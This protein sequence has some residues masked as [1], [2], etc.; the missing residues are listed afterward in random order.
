MKILH[1][2]R[3]IA[4]AALL[5]IL[6][7][8]CGELSSCQTDNDCKDS[9]ICE[10]NPDLEGM[11]CMTPEE[12]EDAR[13]TS[14]EE[15]AGSC[16]NSELAHTNL[17]IVA[18]PSGSSCDMGTVEP[19]REDCTGK[20]GMENWTGRGNED[21]TPVYEEGDDHDVLYGIR[22]ITY[23]ENTLHFGATF[24]YFNT[25]TL[26]KNPTAGDFPAFEDCPNYQSFIGQEEEGYYRMQWENQVNRLLC[27]LDS[28]SAL[29]WGQVRG[30]RS[31]AEPADRICNLYAVR[32]TIEP[33]KGENDCADIE[34]D[35]PYR[36]ECD[37][38]FP[39]INP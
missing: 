20:F 13:N 3:T 15:D 26:R 38:Q 31:G 9:R 22:E 4:Y 37:E 21:M 12:L 35:K 17:W 19:L 32:K 28:D 7:A 8:N 2:A 5:S 36:I 14:T 39:T 1:Q 10:Y 27:Y 24:Q 6:P 25:M 30:G 18:K 16:R 33:W 11:F 23:F 34:R 29:Y